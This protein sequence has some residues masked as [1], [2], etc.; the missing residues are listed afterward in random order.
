MLTFYALKIL[1]TEYKST[2]LT[3]IVLKH[4]ISYNNSRLIEYSAFF[5][6]KKR[7]SCIFQNKANNF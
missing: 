6:G 4:P 7:R 5:S 1:V 3:E 2:K